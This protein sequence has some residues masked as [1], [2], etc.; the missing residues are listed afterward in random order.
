MDVK[1]KFKVIFAIV[2]AEMASEILEK[3]YDAGAE[4][5]TIFYGRGKS[6]HAPEEFLGVPIEPRKEIIMILINEKCA[7]KVLKTVLDAGKLN[8]PGRGL[9]FIVNVDAIEG[10][11]NY[12][13]T[14]S[15]QD[16]F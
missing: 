14:G 15:L 10:I 16:E 12:G 13:K 11:S 5:G 9:A 4:G 7:T 2:K 8:E 1:P 6:K 3:A